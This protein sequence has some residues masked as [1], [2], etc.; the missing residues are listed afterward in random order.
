M[1]MVLRQVQSSACQ[2]R[3]LWEPKLLAGSVLLQQL[4]C[5][6]QAGFPHSHHRSCMSAK[7]STGGCLHLYAYSGKDPGPPSSTPS[8]PVLLQP[9]H[10]RLFAKLTF[11]QLGRVRECPGSWARR[12][13]RSRGELS[14]QHPGSQTSG[15]WSPECLCLGQAQSRGYSREDLYSSGSPPLLLPALLPPVCRDSVSSTAC[16]LVI[17]D[18]QGRNPPPK[19]GP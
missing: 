13:G 12:E 14:A 17:R 7:A 19:P 10:L 3:G 6:I 11:P 18:Q 9:P 1:D 5:R 2:R 16:S 15:S 4:K 8:F